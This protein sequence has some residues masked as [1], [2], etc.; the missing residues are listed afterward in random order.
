MRTL[1]FNAIGSWLR[2]GPTCEVILF[3]DEE[4]VAEAAS[5]L[6]AR[7][8]P[9]VECSDHGTPV[10]S[11]AFQLAQKISTGDL[12]CYVNAD[13]I[14]V[15]DFVQS[16]ARIE[17]K[18]CLVVGRRW[19]LALEAALDFDDPSWEARLL[20]HVCRSGVLHRPQGLDYFVFPRGLFED[21]PPF[22]VGR[23]GW[24]N[25]MVLHARLTGVPVIDAT[26]AI[27]AIHQN[28]D[29]AHLPEGEVTMRSGAEARHN[30][31]L[32]GGRDRSFNVQ[33]ATHVLT[34]TGVRP[35]SGPA[36]LIRRLAKAPELYPHLAPLVKVMLA[37]RVVRGPLVSVK[38]RL[39][40]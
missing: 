40:R 35:A 30:L 13:I 18:P 7:H 26:G 24:D 16:L 27:T 19:D 29:Y 9:E 36:R 21:M 11:S 22:V 12:C 31:E 5:E 14:L 3:G 10:V 39:R 28:H 6:G 17:D 20:A 4:G 34:R 23:V 38:A 32:L 8:V 25:W 1:Q 37:W 33:D 2:L 15:G